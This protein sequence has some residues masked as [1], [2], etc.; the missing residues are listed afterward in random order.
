M[1]LTK[2]RIGCAINPHAFRHAAATSIA[3]ADPEHVQ[4]TKSILGH[5][6]LASSERYYNLAQAFEAAR[7]WDAHVQRLRDGHRDEFIGEE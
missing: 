2:E 5:G 4:I 1:K 7:R 6:S 3:F